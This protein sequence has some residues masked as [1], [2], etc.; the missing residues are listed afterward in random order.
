MLVRFQVLTAASMKITDFWV[1]A[2][3]ILIDIDRRFRDA[4]CLPGYG[5]HKFQ[6]ITAFILFTVKELTSPTTADV[7]KAFLLFIYDFIFYDVRFTAMV[8]SSGFY[9]CF[10]GRP[11]EIMKV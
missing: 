3:C 10:I 5:H 11:C 2:M 6:N 8:N 1:V 4:Y 7:L 9:F